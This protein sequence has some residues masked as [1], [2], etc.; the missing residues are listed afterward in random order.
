MDPSILALVASFAGESTQPSVVLE[1]T[2][3]RGAT[4]SAAPRKGKRETAARVKVIV[5]TKDRPW[6]LQQL[7]R[8]MT[9]QG[10]GSCLVDIIVIGHVQE[11]YIAAYECIERDTRDSID[12]IAGIGFHF[13]KEDDKNSFQA[14]LSRALRQ[15]ADFAMFVTD[16]C[17]LLA[18]LHTILSISAAALDH[19]TEIS[20]FLAR[21]HPGITWSQ[22]R[23]KASPPPRSH[24]R[25]L[26]LFNSTG[27]YTYPLHRGKME[28][29][30]PFDLSGG[31]YRQSTVDLLLDKLKDTNG[32]S[33][34]N[35]FEIC[36]NE[37]LSTRQLSPSL[38]AFPTRPLLLI[39][40]INRVQSIFQAPIASLCDKDYSP[41]SLL[42]YWMQGKHLNLA[43]YQARCFNASHIGDVAL[44]NNKPNETAFTNGPQL[45]VVMP[46]HAGPPSA[47]VHAI[48]SIIMQPITEEPS[49]LRCLQVVLIDDRC[50]DGSIDSMLEEATR[51]ARQY[52]N[53]VSLVIHDFRMPPRSET[54]HSIPAIQITVEV[55]SSPQPGVASAL[56]FGILQCKSTL[57]VRMDADDVAA[58][59]RL[60]AQL[61]LLECEPTLDVVGTQ[62]ILF[63][64]CDYYDRELRNHE[65]KLSATDVPFSLAKEDATSFLARTSLHPTDPGF[66]S[67]ALLF[68][69]CIAHPSVTFRKS[70]VLAVGGYDKTISHAED[71]DLWLRLTSKKSNSVVSIPQIGLWHR[72]HTN[73]SIESVRIQSEQALLLAVSAISNLVPDASHATIETVRQPAKATSISA[74]DE[75]AMLLVSLELKFLDRHATTLTANEVQLIKMDCDDRLGELGT[76]AA[77]RFDNGAQSI[78]WNLWCQRCPDHLLHQL[79]ILAATK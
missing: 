12:Q 63:Q 21:L 48:R 58:Q 46:V 54:C 13:W 24:I 8:S 10:Q 7:I 65:V 77:A 47:A 67:W 79:A 57:V 39:L 34:P 1:R 43:H 30:Y 5:F 53:T 71:Y 61:L 42:S 11:H 69:C 66:V 23:D 60:A 70:A 73:R 40:A 26:P 49:H 17:V 29:N 25:Y 9:L 45:S 32:L 59:G 2:S 68:S 14:L 15:P 52:G 62:T 74:F 28:W 6:Q 55:Y 51:I 41:S 75:A 64:E 76:M 44:G 19:S 37:A 38:C 20:L 22:T 16:D 50:L 72:K 36:G 33:H 18:P 35:R 31:F 27:V 4:H 78:A 3:A 56:N